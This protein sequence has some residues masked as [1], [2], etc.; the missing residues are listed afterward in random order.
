LLPFRFGEPLGNM[1]PLWIEL[2]CLLKGG[3]C[4]RKLPLR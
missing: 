1:G 3:D 2:A 4:F